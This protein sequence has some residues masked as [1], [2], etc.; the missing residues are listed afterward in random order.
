MV[1]LACLG[2]VLVNWLISEVGLTVHFRRSGH[3]PDAMMRTFYRRNI[4]RLFHD[5]GPAYVYHAHAACYILLIIAALTGLWL[6]FG[7]GTLPLIGT[8][9]YLWFYRLRRL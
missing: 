8:Q 3:S 2:A 6:I 1:F 7:L 5:Y 4:V 9:L